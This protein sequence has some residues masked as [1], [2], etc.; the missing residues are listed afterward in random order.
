MRKFL[1]NILLFSL[2]IIIVLAIIF[3]TKVSRGFCYN[4]IKGDCDARGKLFYKRIYSKAH[5]IDYLFI[6]SSK[7]MNGINDDLIEDTINN[8]KSGKL[9]LYNAGY[10]RFGRNLDYLFL[11]EFASRHK[12]K[13]VFLEVRSNESTT[14]H[15]IFPYLASSSEILDGINAVNGKIFKEIYNHELMAIDYLRFKAGFEIPEN[16]S[17]TMKWHGYNNIER[18]MNEKE[19]RDAGLNEINKAEKNKINKD[20]LEFKYSNYYLNRIIS[21]CKEKNIE[22]S[23]IYLP[24]FGG[25]KVAPAF[26]EEYNKEGKVIFGP[27]SI[28]KNVTYW[29]DAAHFNTA[30][31]TAYSN[32]LAKELTR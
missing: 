4:Y 12:L 18:I 27:D 1:V 15:P 16:N 26:L 23:F 14:S 17:E 7:T 2:P 10:C 19:L 6:G 9:R 28:Y 5:T 3:F 20:A 11:K 13:K 25:E 31:A 8:G 30:G 24:S 21:F 32:F 29:K 22:L